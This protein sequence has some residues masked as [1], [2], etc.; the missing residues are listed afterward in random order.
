MLLMPRTMLFLSRFRR[1]KR[2]VTAVEFAMVALPFFFLL[3][4]IIDISLIFF[5]QT[6]LENGV[7][8]A[9]RQIRTGEAQASNMTAAQFRTLVCNQINMLLGCDARLG[10]DVRRFNN[11]G[12]INL[13]AALD[14]NGN[15]SGNMTFDP[16]AAGDIVVV[17]AFYSWPMLT[18]TVGENFSNM[19][20]NHRLLSTSLA[21]RNEPF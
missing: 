16:G 2:G 3:Y 6:T 19:S 20:G 11:F 18:P 1:D 14:N 8:S 7:V 13:P 15:L 21:F 17:R 9:A 5:A 4:A 10:I 12:G